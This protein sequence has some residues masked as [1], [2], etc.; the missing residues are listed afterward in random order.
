MVHP[1][2]HVELTRTVFKLAAR[3]G[4]QNLLPVMTRTGERPIV[5]A[6]GSDTVATVAK[7]VSL[8]GVANVCVREGSRIHVM[9]WEQNHSHDEFMADLLGTGDVP[10]QVHQKTTMSMLLTLVRDCHEQGERI[11]LQ[12]EDSGLE[13]A[14]PSV[15]SFA[16]A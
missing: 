16:A 9:G 7:K 10:Q 13:A 14:I 8:H 6:V 3:V 15:H 5:V 2:A 1:R 11:A 12:V 4:A